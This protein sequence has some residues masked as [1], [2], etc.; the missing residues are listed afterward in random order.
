MCTVLSASFLRIN[1]FLCRLAHRLSFPLVDD[2]SRNIYMFPSEESLKITRLKAHKS[3]L[4]FQP[5]LPRFVRVHSERSRDGAPRDCGLLPDTVGLNSS[6]PR[7]LRG[8][9]AVCFRATR[10][11]EVS[12]HNYNY[13][14]DKNMT[15]Q[16]VPNAGSWTFKGPSG[17]FQGPY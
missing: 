11:T 9:M 15:T 8:G 10:S 12:S 4:F 16:G 17:G 2:T 5:R 3:R 14:C 1:S 6:F 13:M 7:T